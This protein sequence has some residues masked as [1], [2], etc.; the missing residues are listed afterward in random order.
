MVY[1][2][3]YDSTHNRFKGEVKE[4][5]GLLVVNGKKIQVFQQR[6]P[7]DIPWGKAGAEIVVESTGVFTT[8]EKAKAHIQGGAK[9]VVIS[10]PSADAKMIVMGVNQEVC[11]AKIFFLAQM[12]AIFNRFSLLFTRLMIPMMKSSRMRRV[13]PIAWLLWPRSLMTI[14]ALRPVS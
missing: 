14:G 10:A 6:N 9:K 11:E 8:I 5:G 13:L 3:K 12:S 7:A 2:F 4:E 1:M